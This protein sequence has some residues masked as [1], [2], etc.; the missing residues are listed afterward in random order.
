MEYGWESILLKTSN[1]LTYNFLQINI[2]IAH[3]L[4]SFEI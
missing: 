2:S 3:E 1:I 4:F